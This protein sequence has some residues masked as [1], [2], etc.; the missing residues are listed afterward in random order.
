MVARSKRRRQSSFFV[1]KSFVECTP[2]CK[3]NGGDDDYCMKCKAFCR[4]QDIVFGCPHCIAEYN[5]LNWLNDLYKHYEK[6]LID[7]EDKPAWVGQC[8]LLV[9]SEVNKEEKKRMS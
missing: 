3:C 4:T 2:E 1:A 7:I 8:L 9:Q 5:R 6:G